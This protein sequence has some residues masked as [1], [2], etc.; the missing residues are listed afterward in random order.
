MHVDTRRHTRGRHCILLHPGLNIML[1]S[2]C[3]C[4]R[5]PPRARI[6]SERS[7]INNAASKVLKLF[8]QSKSQCFP[9]VLCKKFV[10]L[11]IH[12]K[13]LIIPCSENSQV[14]ANFEG[15]M[16]LKGLCF[17]S[18]TPLPGYKSLF[19]VKSGNYHNFVPT[20]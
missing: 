15:L 9:Q 11:A 10:T 14:T 3:N 6:Y 1:L 16:I 13:N 12:L 8:L 4:L 17:Q 19:C 20:Q 18:L 5:I 7:H 2:G